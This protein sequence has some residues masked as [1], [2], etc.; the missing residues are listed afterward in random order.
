V[1]TVSYSRKMADGTTH[2]LAGLSTRYGRY[3][4]THRAEGEIG[5]AVHGTER[6]YLIEVADL[7][8]PVVGVTTPQRGDRINDGGQ[9]WEL[10]SPETGEACW[11]YSDNF[12]TLYRVFTKRL[13]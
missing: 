5:L 6:V 8:L 13:L 7:V 1:P 12:R 3:L 11:R 2:T 4:S 9:V 10:A